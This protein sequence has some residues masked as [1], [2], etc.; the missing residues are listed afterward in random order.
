MR[1]LVW[2]ELAGLCLVLSSCAA[3]T[4]EATRGSAV[5]ADDDQRASMERIGRKVDGLIVWSTS[6]VGNHDLWLMKTDGSD[7]R[8]LTRNDKVDW[9]PRFSPDGQTVLFCRSKKGY[10]FERDA[11]MHHKWDTWTIGVDGKGEKL[12]AED[13]CWGTWLAP[14][15]IMVNRDTRVYAVPLGGGE[16]ELLADS[17]AIESLGGAALQQP[18]MS[19]DGKYLAITL[20]GARR[21]TGILDLA[22]KTWTKTGEGCQINWHPAGDRIYWDNPS[23][24]GGSEIFSIEVR[25]GRPAREYDYEQMRLID[26]PGRRSHEYFPQMSAGGNWLVWAATRRGHDHDVA[27][28]EIYIWEIGAPAEEATR[29]TFHSGNDRWPDIFIPGEKGP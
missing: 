3:L 18:Q 20:R 28:Y 21:E 17:R 24:N 4:G 22:A 19:P 11:N 13:A 6:R 7:K 12:V 15:R 25:D 9:F 26:I 1:M 27:D 8:A 16:D 14:D 10:V 29:L 2:V 23:G 5:E